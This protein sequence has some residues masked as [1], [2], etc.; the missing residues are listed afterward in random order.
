MLHAFERHIKF[1]I[2]A[3]TVLNMHELSSPFCSKTKAEKTLREHGG[4]VVGALASL[5]N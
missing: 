3:G 5:T 2:A 4:N 1:R